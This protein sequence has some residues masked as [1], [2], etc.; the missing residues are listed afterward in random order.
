MFDDLNY[1]PSTGEFIWNVSK[2][3]VK[4]GTKAGCKM[5]NGY[6]AIRVN[7]KLYLAHR[8]AFYKMFGRFPNQIDHINRVRDDNRLENLREVTPRK[9]STNRSCN[10]KL[11]LGVYET[12]RKGRPGVWYST[13]IQWLGKQYS[14]SFRNL[15]DAINWRK[16]K[17][18]DL[19]GERSSV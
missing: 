16:R 17:E 19:F 8:I 13:K 18:K 5:T 6:I 7:N 9:N 10:R 12:I 14:S 2:R 4:K 15:E 3:S 11:P 1:E